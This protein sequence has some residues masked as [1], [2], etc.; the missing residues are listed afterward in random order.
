M[1]Y[2]VIP[3]LRAPLQKAAGDGAV[4]SLAIAPQGENVEE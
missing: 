2:G 1:S 3:Q 4:P